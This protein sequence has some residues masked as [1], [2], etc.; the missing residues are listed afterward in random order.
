MRRLRPPTGPARR[1]AAPPLLALLA[2]VAVPA[3]AACRGGDASPERRAFVD[4]RD[5]YDPRSLDPALS[6]DVPTGR[7]VSYVFDGL[8]RFTPDARVEPALARRWEVTPD[9]TV[10]TF[11]L[12]QGVSYHDG[13][14]FRAADVAASFARALSPTNKGGR[15]WPLLPIRG[16][17]AYADGRATSLAG[18]RVVN[19]TTVV[20]TLDEP[21]AI[22]PKLLAMPVASIVPPNPGADF[23]QRP[24]GTGPWKLVE[25]RHDDYLKFARH[26]KYFAGTPGADTLVARIIPEPSTQVAEFEAGNVDLLTVPLGETRQWEQT[27]ERSARLQTAPALVLYYVAINTTRGPLKDA[28]V[29]QALN[30]AIDTRTILERLI[31]G[32]GRVAAG[33]IPEAVDAQAAAARP[34]YAYDVARAKRLLAEA[35]HP[36]GIDVELWSS[37][38]ATLAR[39]A[40]S[41]QGYLNAAGIRAKIVQRDAS[42]VREAARNGQVDLFVKTWYADYPDADAFLTPLLASESRG[43]GGN[44]SFY[45]SRTVDSLVTRARRTQDDAE[46]AR[47]SRQADS[48]AFADAPMAYLFF[49]N[50]L[51]A[52]QPW[53]RNFQPPVIF[54][55]QRW[56]DVK[57]DRPEAGA[58]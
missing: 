27:D 43:V 15:A 4:S 47:L 44:Y 6:T 5:T 14:P 53:I 56:L 19:D 9:G 51:Y 1:P 38:D 12:H 17:A 13:R 28:R 11:H 31:A 24:I 48:V 20:I 32:R 26:E 22:F 33:V 42:S 41:V 2:A 25:W 8:T 36:N 54:N 34:A 49:Y 39:L 37:Q 45:A 16:A 35:G 29:R 18:V 23:G 52:V 57:F 7:A 40:Q 58:P 3:L 30:H 55:G 10:Y 21:L 46:R 50:D